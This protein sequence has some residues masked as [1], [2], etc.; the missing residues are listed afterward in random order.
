MSG[1]FQTLEGELAV[2]VENGVYREA[3]LAV[4]NNGELYVK[5]KGGYLRLYADGS[6]SGGS[7]CRLDTLA[8]DADFYTDR[9]GRLCI[10]KGTD[11]KPLGETPAFLTIEKD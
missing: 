6:T 4:R 3:A 9:L 11:R 8:L 10:A 5:A 1:M 7:K 2:T